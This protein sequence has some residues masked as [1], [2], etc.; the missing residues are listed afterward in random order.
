MLDQPVVTVPV[1]EHNALKERV[2]MLELE[3]EKVKKERDDHLMEVGRTIQGVYSNFALLLHTT[4]KRL[5]EMENKTNNRFVEMDDKIEGVLDETHAC[6]GGL[7]TLRERVNKIDEDTMDLENRFDSLG[8]GHK[9]SKTASPASE[10]TPV[11]EKPPITPALASANNDPA[12]SIKV[13]LMP[14]SSGHPFSVDS[15]EFQRCLSRNLLR[16]LH[17]SDDSSFAFISAV[18]EAFLKLLRNRSWMPLVVYNPD[19]CSSEGQNSVRGLPAEKCSP[20]LW[21]RGF[22]REYCLHYEKGL[23]EIIYISLASGDLSWK[24]VEKLRPSRDID[25]SCWL[26]IPELDDMG[27]NMIHDMD[28]FGIDDDGYDL[29]PYTSRAPSH[30]GQISASEPQLWIPPPQAD[31]IANCGFDANEDPRTMKKICLPTNPESRTTQRESKSRKQTQYI[32]GRSKRKIS[33]RT[34]S[35]QTSSRLSDWKLPVQTLLHSHSTKDKD[36]DRT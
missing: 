25:Q 17:V 35:N 23:G 28:D 12:W 21:D 31:T 3:L 32:S 20:E 14:Q 13:M 34:K 11:P 6:H 16:E 27:A 24:D 15:V 10:A 1:E 8:L 18:D 7:D 33:V 9:P 19:P 22:L 4:T 29:P 30:V 2:T 5:F 26:H 36:V